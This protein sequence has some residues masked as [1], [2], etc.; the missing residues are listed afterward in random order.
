MS[1]RISVAALCVGL[2]AVAWCAVAAM[3]VQPGAGSEWIVWSLAGTGCTLIVTGG[4][5]LLGDF[6]RDS[7]CQPGAGF[8]CG[9]LG[10]F[11]GGSCGM[12]AGVV[13]Y[14]ILRNL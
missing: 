5:G 13:G 3:H 6:N 7:F 8:D 11:V 1:K 10:L 14:A 4:R 2:L 9:V 12:I